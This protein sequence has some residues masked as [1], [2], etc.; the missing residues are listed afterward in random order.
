MSEKTMGCM[1]KSQ[2]VVLEFR[3]APVDLVKRRRA[4]VLKTSMLNFGI[5]R[6]V[7]PASVLQ[8]V[9]VKSDDLTHVA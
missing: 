7:R 6:I 5:D 4:D 2:G 1:S 9:F 3:I 8:H